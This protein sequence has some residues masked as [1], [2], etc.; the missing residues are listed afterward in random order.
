MQKEDEIMSNWKIY[1]LYYGELDCPKGAI[2]PGLDT[3][4]PFTI[5]YMGYLLDNGSKKILVDTG[6]NERFI[7]DGKAWGGF[8]AQ[9]GTKYVSDS[10]AKI[11]V[12]PEDIDV[13][14][15]THLHNDH[16]GAS[17][18]FAKS[19]HIFQE[20]EWANLLDPLP[21]QKIRG[22]YDPETIPV[23]KEMTCLKI[24]G[25]V[26]IEPGVTT[27]KTAGHTA[28]SMS[29]AVE[30][31]KGLYVLTGDTA[32]LNCMLYPK[33]STMSLMNGTKVKITPAPDVYGPAIPSS[34]VY[35]HYAWYRSIYLLKTLI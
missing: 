2:T 5:P 26:E 32:I 27:Y 7:I 31:D 14:L 23:L 25:T 34:L 10:L 12:N 15:Y 22:D 4:L 9:G 18:I 1:S 6:I 33:S 13:V 21:S 35:D 20:D 29:V 11:G 28:G 30:T 19:V 24:E 16:T 3:D 17:H 8:R